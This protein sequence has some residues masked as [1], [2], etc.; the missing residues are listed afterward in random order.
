[1]EKNLIG[2]VFHEIADSIESGNFSKK[3]K[4]AV[5][6][7]G[8]ELGTETVNQAIRNAKS[9]LYD[10]VVIGE[11]FSDEFETYEA[12]CG[13]D[14]YDTMEKLLDEKKIDACITM[15]YNFPIGVATIGRVITP[16]RGREM[17]IASTTGTSAIDRVEAML[18]NAI[19]G[20]I[21]AKASGIDKPKVGILNVDGARSVEKA[22]NQLKANGFDIEFAVSDRADGGAVMRGNDLIRGTSDIMVT[23]TL[24]GN[25]LMKMFSSFNS[26]GDYEV[27]G[28][29]YGPGIGIDFERNIFIISRAS[30][31]PV[32]SNAIRYAYDMLNG[33][34]NRIRKEVYEEAKKN[35]FEEIVNELVQSIKATCD[36]EIKMP[37]KEIVSKEIAGIDILEI[38]D[39]VLA[40]WK[41]NIYAESGMGCTGPIVIV[42]EANFD[43]AK[44]IL[45]DAHFI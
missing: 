11:K 16:Y 20:K 39:A 23:D 30:G 37:E 14:M 43:K 40:L 19:A 29:G 27:S 38:E 22:L 45:E 6:N 41:E 4:I 2:K 1:M 34:I 9:N 36:E 32:I 28:Y 12:D 18:R 17:F 31:I 44:K 10:I 24:T 5:T 35:G 15:H 3:F 33:D 25:L 21:A 26:G 8:S 7:L 13:E 42:S